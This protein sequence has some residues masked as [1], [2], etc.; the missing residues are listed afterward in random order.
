M[1]AGAKALW[2]AAGEVYGRSGKFRET[3]REP[4][5]ACV[6]IIPCDCQ[7]AT[8][9]AGTAARADEPAND[10]V[11]E[12]RSCGNGTKGPR[13]SDRAL[14]AAAGPREFLLIRR[15]PSRE[16][17]QYT[18]YLCRA[19]EGRPA[20]MTYFITIAGRHWPVE[21]DPGG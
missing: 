15:L 21:V 4:G 1:A 8:T 9:A 6:V 10:A 7:A 14:I 2:T 5:L 11:F 19:P 17:S 12:R 20:T 3:C 16:K 18:F 13:Y